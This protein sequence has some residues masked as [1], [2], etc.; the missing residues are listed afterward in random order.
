MLSFKCKTRH[1]EVG[2]E[3]SGLLSNIQQ[4]PYHSTCQ[5]HN[6]LTW[7]LFQA[8]GRNEEAREDVFVNNRRVLSDDRIKRSYRQTC[9]VADDIVGLD[10][11]AERHRKENR[12]LNLSE[13]EATVL[14]VL[15]P[16][17][18]SKKRSRE[19]T[20]LYRSLTQLGDGARW[21]CAYQSCWDNRHWREIRNTDADSSARARLLETCRFCRESLRVKQVVY[22]GNR[23]VRLSIT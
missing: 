14:V 3:R 23:I 17:I 10:N 1:I 11:L 8:L 16:G 6:E 18:G 2:T 21:V 7:F 15:E 20:L 12:C 4:Q 9:L 13:C 19:P 22:M 5:R